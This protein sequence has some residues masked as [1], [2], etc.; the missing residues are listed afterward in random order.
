MIDTPHVVHTPAALT[1]VIRITVPRDAMRSVMGP[2]IR[3]LFATLAAQGITPSGAWF[4]HHLRMDPEVFDF[5]IGV[6]VAESVTVAGRV[7]PSVRPML[8][9]ARTVYHGPYEGLGTAWG[10]LDAWVADGGHTPGPDRWECYA[11]GP[12]SS[13][14]PAAWRTEL[15]RP[16]ASIG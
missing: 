11:A 15:E 4:A 8:R 10:A 9:V 5:E 12:E 1:A 14:D 13:A 3:E 6:P 2:G 16:L 7:T